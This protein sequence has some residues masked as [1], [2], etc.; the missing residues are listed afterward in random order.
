MPKGKEIPKRVGA[1]VKEG[2]TRLMVVNNQQQI[3][4]TYYLHCSDCGRVV[5]SID[6]SPLDLAESVKSLV[7]QMLESATYCPKCGRKLEYILP[8]IVE[9]EYVELNK[10]Y[11]DV[12]PQPQVE[13]E[14]K[15]ENKDKQ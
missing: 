12:P 15:E 7:P 8:D 2:S 13:S 10:T 11:L 6:S 14:V 9:G 4:H 1:I 5:Y 3:F